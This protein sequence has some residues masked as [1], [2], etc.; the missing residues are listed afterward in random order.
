MGFFSKDKFRN[1][2]P[3]LQAGEYMDITSA[4]TSKQSVIDYLT[5]LSN[6]EYTKL[7][8]VVNIYRNADKDV[9]KVL[10]IKQNATIMTGKF[11]GDFL[12]DDDTELGNFLDDDHD[13][14]ATRKQRKTAE[15][16]IKSKKGK[17]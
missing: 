14:P 16:A 12:S 15:T 6:Q 9:K 7:L 11:D 10:N 4:E 5:G 13:T 3:L 8:K 17:L 1:L 2:P